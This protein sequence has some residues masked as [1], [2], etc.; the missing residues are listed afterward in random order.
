MEMENVSTPVEYGHHA[1]TPAR[2]L[3]LVLGNAR[4]NASD[5]ST[6]HS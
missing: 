3:T 1:I 6:S 2:T 5:A 4:S